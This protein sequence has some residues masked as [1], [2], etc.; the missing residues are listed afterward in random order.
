MGDVRACG[1]A[2]A[3]LVAGR[4]TG[5]DLDMELVLDRMDPVENEVVPDPSLV[6]RYEVIR[7]VADRVAEAVLGL[8]L[9]GPDGGGI[10]GARI[11][12][13]AGARSA[14]V[15]GGGGDTT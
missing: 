15:T 7:H 11:A 6:E 4:V 14:G 8:R 9:S 5:L 2:G 10:A 1:A 3:A 13:I 12:G